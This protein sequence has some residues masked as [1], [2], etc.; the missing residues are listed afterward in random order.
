[1]SNESISLLT[2]AAAKASG[3]MARKVILFSSGL[4]PHHFSLGTR[5]RTF[6]DLLNLSTLYGPAS[7]SFFSSD[8]P[9][10][11]VSGS[12]TLSALLSLGLPPKTDVQ[13]GYGPLKVT[14]ASNLSAPCLMSVIES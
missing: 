1:M 2:N 7:H 9:S 6:S 3:E 13:S 10:L 4:A 12:L 11:K 8:Q 14:V 5:V